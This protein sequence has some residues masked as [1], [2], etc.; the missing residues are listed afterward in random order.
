MSGVFGTLHHH[1]LLLIQFVL[2]NIG[3]KRQIQTLEQIIKLRERFLTEVA[4]LQEVSLVILN[5][6]AESLNVG[7]LQTVEST[8]TE[9]HVNQTSLKQLT[10]VENLLIELLIAIR[11]IVLESNLLIREQHEMMNQNLGG[12][13]EGVLR[14]YGTIRHHLQQELVI[15]GLLFNSIGLY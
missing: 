8:D 13:L 5:Q 6:V 15:V 7:S 10:H 12:F 11:I 2:R 1:L 14:V 4:E 9:V 3:S